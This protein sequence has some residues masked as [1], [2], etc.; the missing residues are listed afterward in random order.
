MA[1]INWGVGYVHPSAGLSGNNGFGP[2]TPKDSIQNGISAGFLHLRVAAGTH[3]VSSISAR[4]TLEFMPGTHIFQNAP[5]TM[6]QTVF[7]LISSQRRAPSLDGVGA[8]KITAPGTVASFFNQTVPTDNVYGGL[9]RGLWFDM[10]K[11]SAAAVDF[12]NVNMFKVEDNIGYRA[13]YSP[14]YMFRSEV[15]DITGKSED[16]SYGRVMRNIA[17]NCGLMS[18]NNPSVAPIN[19]WNWR[20]NVCVAP[21]GDATVPFIN[22]QRDRHQGILLE[23]NT[24]D[25]MGSGGSAVYFG[26]SHS[27]D[28]IG[29]HVANCN[30]TENVWLD[31]DNQGTADADYSMSSHVIHARGV[32]AQ[33]GL[34]RFNTTV[35]PAGVESYE[36]THKIRADIIDYQDNL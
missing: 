28:A 13:S 22:K 11:I 2:D 5:V 3:T 26:R 32:D 19:R 27:V 16:S 4:V 9:V 20:D 17:W 35:F 29:N 18:D 10:S 33:G 30:T 8:A 12:G 14:V 24:F 21:S 15:V 31:C 36:P 1:A 34:V 25:G 7:N 6:S 23:G